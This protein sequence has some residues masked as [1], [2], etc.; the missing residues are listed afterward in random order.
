MCGWHMG[1]WNAG[2]WLAMCL[3]MLVF[4]SLVVGGIIA[5]V[6]HFSPGTRLAGPPATDD[7]REVLRLRLAKGEIDEAEFAKLSEVLSKAPR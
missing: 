5:L 7:T 2:N 4:W 6:H 1:S 3:M